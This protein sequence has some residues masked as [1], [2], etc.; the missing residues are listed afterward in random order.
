MQGSRAVNGAEDVTFAQ[1]PAMF[2]DDSG[3]VAG[4]VGGIGSVG[5]SI[6]PLVFSAYFLPSLHWGF[7]VVGVTMVP[8]LVLSAWVFQPHV[9][10]EATT[11]GWLLSEPPARSGAPADD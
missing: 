8:I 3:S 11:G 10:E 1:V 7:A 4:I 2:P 9:A 6:Y 5:G